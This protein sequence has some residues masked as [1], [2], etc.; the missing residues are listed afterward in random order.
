[1]KKQKTETKVSSH[2]PRTLHCHE[3]SGVD[4]TMHV[5]DRQPDSSSGST[6]KNRVVTGEVQTNKDGEQYI[7]VST[8]SPQGASQI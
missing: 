4:C 6:K 5:A 8:P 2:N 1:M 3:G 7:D